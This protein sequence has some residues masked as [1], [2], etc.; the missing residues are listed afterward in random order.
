MEKFSVSMCVYHGDTPA[1]FRMAVE[2]VLNQTVKP[3]EIVLVV[4]GP[5]PDE[6]KAVICE[7]ERMDM[8]RVIW[9]PE[10]KGHGE[11][12]RAGLEQCT[13]ELVA[14]MD[15][16]DICSPDRFEHQLKAFCEDPDLAVVGGQIE[17][18]IDEIENVAGCR[19]VPLLNNKI[20]KDLKK[21]CPMNQ[22]T[23]MFRKQAVLQVGGYRDW[24][25]NE[26]YYLWNR[27]YLAGMKF[28]NVPQILVHVRVGA[29]MYNRRGGWKY[30]LSEY[31]MQNYMMRNGII[32]P[33]T[34]L[35][36]V[37]KRFIV[38]VLLPNKVRGIVFKRFAR[39][40][41]V[42]SEDVYETA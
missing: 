9:F 20:R 36:N 26:D 34:W 37:S 24:Y 40:S 2:S 19:I 30:F 31:K 5:V 14:L 22:V 27:M 21:R 18:F 41:S 25:C 16:D 7:Y 42:K 28:G 10:N 23:V 13:H 12:R 3:D 1:W 4:D 35:I 38:Q 15:A 39:K 32:G 11:A 33:A 29:D 6:L 8:F 17:E